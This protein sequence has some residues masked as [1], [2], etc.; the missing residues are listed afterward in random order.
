MRV[1]TDITIRFRDF[2]PKGFGVQAPE[3]SAAKRRSLR[4]TARAM[5]Q[6]NVEIVKASFEAWNALDVDAIR[7]FYAEDAVIETGMTGL[8]R[9]FEGDDPIGHWVAELQETWAEIHWEAERIFEADDVVVSFYR[10]IG[11]GRWSGIEVEDE[12]AGVY[13]IRDGKIARERIYLDREEALEAVGLS[14]QDTHA[15]S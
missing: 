2:P 12:V 10:G 14:E 15:E 13:H 5:S 4:D 3:S 6:E 8:G 7:R 9:T 1:S 11:V